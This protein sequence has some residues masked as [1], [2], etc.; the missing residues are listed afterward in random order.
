MKRQEVLASSTEIS[1]SSRTKSCKFI[2]HCLASTHEH[3][4]LIIL[5]QLSV[6]TQDPYTNPLFIFL[7]GKFL[8]LSGV[9]YS[10]DE[11]TFLIKQGIDVTV[12]QTEEFCISDVHCT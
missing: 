9:G 6:R 5:S 11:F 3:P 7:S 2:M 8:H 1:M 4:T 10:A 12:H